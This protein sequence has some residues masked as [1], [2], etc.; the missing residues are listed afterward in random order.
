MPTSS[1]KCLAI[2]LPVRTRAVIRCSKSVR[3][4]KTVVIL[5]VTSDKGLC[6]S[7]NTNLINSSLKLARAKAAEGK[8]VKFYCVGKKGA[9]TIRRSEFEVATALTDSM[10]NFDFTLANRLGMEIIGAYLR[11]E[12]DEVHI[13]YGHFVNIAKQTPELLQILPIQGHDAPEGEVAKGVSGDYTYEPSVEGLLVE[14][15]PPLHQG[16]DLQRPFGYLGQ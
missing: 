8:E 12:M 7:F 3:K 1:T 9:A 16:A 13:V 4:I 2:W 5:L 14:L 15:L 10:S 6:G 11:G